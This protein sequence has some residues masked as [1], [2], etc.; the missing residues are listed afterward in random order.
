[1]VNIS[2]EFDNFS[3]RK[4]E[5]FMIVDVRIF[6]DQI[7][8]FWIKKYWMLLFWKKQRNL[9]WGFNN[10]SRRKYAKIAENRDHIIDPRS[11]DDCMAACVDSAKTC[12]T[13]MFDHTFCY[14]SNSTSYFL[15]TKT[16]NNVVRVFSDSNRVNISSM[17]CESERLLLWSPNCKMSKSKPSASKCRNTC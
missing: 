3:A 7:A 15:Y 17:P 2:S 6:F 12:T 14:T 4:L 5:I 9:T 13:F 1:M 11:I 16:T 8:E 10:F